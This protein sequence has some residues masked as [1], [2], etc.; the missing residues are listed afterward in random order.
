MNI[1]LFSVG[2]PGPNN[3]HSAGH[4]VLQRLITGFGAKQL[5]KKAKYS[6][7]SMDNIYFVKS[8]AYMNESGDALRSFVNTEKLGLCVV[9]VL[10]DDFEIS[11]PKVRLR[12]IRE[13]DSHNGI[14]SVARVVKE[15]SLEGYLLGV[16]IGPKPSNATRDTMASWVLSPFT[17]DESKRLEKSMDAVYKF[18]NIIVSADGVIGDSN[19]ITARVNKSI[20]AAEENR[21]M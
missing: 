13:K 19:K 8:N 3:R 7:T 9:V 20:A 5:I 16:G 21:D 15:Q 4:W 14:K 6:I 12:Q 18:I 2:N 11:M 17:Q 10:Y 1:V